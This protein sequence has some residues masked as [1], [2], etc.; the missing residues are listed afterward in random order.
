MICA[1]NDT[2]HTPDR[3]CEVGRVNEQSEQDTANAR[4][5]AAAPELLAACEG[6]QKYAHTIA[7]DA[8][9]DA[10][11]PFWAWIE[12]ATDAI[13]KTKKS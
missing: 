9:L 6:L 2:Y 13:A 5:I 7:E 11:H 12:D 1:K 4:L 8:G 3:I 10:S